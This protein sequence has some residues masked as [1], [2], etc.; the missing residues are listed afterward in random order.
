MPKQTKADLILVLQFALGL[1]P[2][3]LV[4]ILSMT[5]LVYAS[6]NSSSAIPT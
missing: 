3:R 6:L 2:Y 1:T 4:W 5:H